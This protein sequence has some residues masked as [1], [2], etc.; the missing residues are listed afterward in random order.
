MND[1]T[2]KSGL[3]LFIV[4]F[5]AGILIWWFLSGPCL[6]KTAG[7]H[8]RSK[9]KRKIKIITFTGPSGAGKTTIV[10]E[11]LKKHPEWGIVISLTSRE[12]RDS[13]LPG[14]Y[15]CGLSVGYLSQLEKE[16][17]ALWLEGEHGNI[18]VTLF[19]DVNDA[20]LTRTLSFM[21]IL[22][23][24]VIKLCLYIPQEV[25]SVFI[26]PPGEEEQRRRLEKRGELSK[27][28]ERRIADCNKWEEEA[29]ASCVPYY[30]VTNDGTVAEVVAKVEKIIE[31]NI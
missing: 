14:E 1:L 24:S 4:I 7:G 21:Q 13:D 18:Y 5:W 26:L 19:K 31:E 30:F 27:Q 17:K 16:G 9:L 10:G 28:I 20:C 15:R 8:I 11:L 3:F 12:S 29:R 23:K 25:L 22:H 2:L 6:T